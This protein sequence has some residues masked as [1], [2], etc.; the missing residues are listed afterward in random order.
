[1][2]IPEGDIV[3]RRKSSNMD[4]V[5]HVDGEQTIKAPNVSDGL[6]AMPQ[7]QPVPI[8]IMVAIIIKGIPEGPGEM[9]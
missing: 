6:K 3:N 2:G 1:M 5:G 8:R 4:T 7:A 9:Y